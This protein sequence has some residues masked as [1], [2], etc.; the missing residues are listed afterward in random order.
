MCSMVPA[1]S[2]AGHLGTHLPGEGGLSE[3]QPPLRPAAAGGS[4]QPATLLGP[5]PTGP[6][7]CRRVECRVSE[8]RGGGEEQ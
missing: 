7:P 1:Y 5:G 6:R 3:G 2:S 8:G 4:T